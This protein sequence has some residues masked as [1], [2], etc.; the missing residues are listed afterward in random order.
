VVPA[1][2]AT[3]MQW[4]VAI[5]LLIALLTLLLHVLLCYITRRWAYMAA[6]RTQGQLLPDSIER[7][8]LSGKKKKLK[9]RKPRPKYRTPLMLHY[10]SSTDCSL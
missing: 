6:S 5:S 2:D 3:I 7:V 4:T 1:E 8:S 9:R 10:S